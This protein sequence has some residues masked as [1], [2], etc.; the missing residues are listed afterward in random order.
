MTKSITKLACVGLMTVGGALAMGQDEGANREARARA[1]EIQAQQQK[2]IAVQQDQAEQQR[3]E[4]QRALEAQNTPPPAP[5][6]GGGG[7]RVFGGPGGMGGEEIKLL[8]QFD[9]EKDKKLNAAERKEAL[10]HLAKEREARPG[11]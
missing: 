4:A 2:Q 3:R 5:A 9:K 8:K 11:R 6:G 1:Q 10:A 7:G